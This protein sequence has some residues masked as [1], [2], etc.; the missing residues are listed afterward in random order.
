MG[1]GVRKPRWGNL[2][3]YSQKPIMEASAKFAADRGEAT[4]RNATFHVP[5]FP[6]TAD[7]AV[8]EKNTY[9]NGRARAIIP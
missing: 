9:K 7:V 6:N 3:Q 2:P 1:Y 4:M 5:Y 8:A